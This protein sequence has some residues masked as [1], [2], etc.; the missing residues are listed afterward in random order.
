V[1]GVGVLVN[2]EN[3]VSEAPS[4]RYNETRVGTYFIK[5][6]SSTAQKKRNIEQIANALGLDIEVRIV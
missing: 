3:I 2:G 5:T 1:A 4:S 6:H